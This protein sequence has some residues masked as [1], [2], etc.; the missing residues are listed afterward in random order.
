[1]VFIVT[2][3]D[4]F[5]TTPILRQMIPVLLIVQQLSRV[6]VIQSSMFSRFRSLYEDLNNKPVILTRDERCKKFAG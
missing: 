5:Q 3:I 1:M 6:K 4:K 2:V